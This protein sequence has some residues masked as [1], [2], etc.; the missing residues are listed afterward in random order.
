MARPVSKIE[1]RIFFDRT[2][3]GIDR[4]ALSPVSVTAN[5]FFE[6]VEKCFHES[7]QLNPRK[8]DLRRIDFT[9]RVSYYITYRFMWD[10]DF[11][12]WTKLLNLS[13][14]LKRPWHLQNEI[15]SFLCCAGAKFMPLNNLIEFSERTAEVNP[16][17]LAL[18]DETLISPGMI[19]SRRESYLEDT[20]KFIDILLARKS[21]SKPGLVLV[22]LRQACLRP[23]LGSICRLVVPPEEMVVKLAEFNPEEYPEISQLVEG[24]FE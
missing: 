4:F 22:K 3:P 18:S 9:S 16:F 6:F 7:P 11:S 13:F 20:V 8:S 12:R 2:F 17:P 5:Y 10:G 24:Y 23:T 14:V 19:P 1:W 21:E 15:H